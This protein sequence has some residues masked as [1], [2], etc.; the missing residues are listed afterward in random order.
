MVLEQESR[1]REE[2]RDHWAFQDYGPIWRIDSLTEEPEGLNAA[3]NCAAVGIQRPCSQHAQ[4]SN[5]CTKDLLFLKQGLSLSVF[6]DNSTTL[7][8]V[9]ADDTR[10]A[11]QDRENEQNAH[12]N[13]GEDPLECDDVS[14]ELGDAEGYRNC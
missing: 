10:E 14:E 13:K 7:E 11:D 12:D 9:L 5:L 3:A 4:I 8:G 6:V 2:A 1:S